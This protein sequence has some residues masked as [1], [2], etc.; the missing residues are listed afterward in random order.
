[1][2]MEQT[3]LAAQVAVERVVTLQLLELQILAVAVAVQ[4]HPQAQAAQA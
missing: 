3:V 4:V 2:L 1:M